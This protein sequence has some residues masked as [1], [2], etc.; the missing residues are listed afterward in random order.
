MT[1]LLAFQRYWFRP[2]PAER[3]AALRVIVGLFALVY[4]IV[5]APHLASYAHFRAADFRP[6]GVVH[7][8]DAPLPAAA[9]YLILGLCITGGIAFV[10]GARYRLS[11]PVFALSFLW[12]TSYRCSWG[13]IF[14]QDNLVALHLLILCTASAADVW[15]FDGRGR[16]PAP[17]DERYGWPIRALTWVTLTSYVLA[18]IAKLEHAGAGWATGQILREHIAYDALRKIQLG[19]LYSP[20]GA[21]LVHFDGVFP[22]LGAM[23]LLLELGAPIAALGGRVRTGWVL[24]VWGFHV[25]VM[26][27]MAI[28]FVYPL[29]GCAFASLFEVER[30]WPALTR[31]MKWLR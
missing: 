12:L 14:H 18:G 4:V 11:G 17:A 27:L 16:A 3:L 26:V 31:R 25:G 8:L 6:V 23:T 5:R 24:G 20:V 15:S 10:A 1:P 28:T 7:L 13:M 2:Q 21:W 30:L 29:S 19:G 9:T 22:L